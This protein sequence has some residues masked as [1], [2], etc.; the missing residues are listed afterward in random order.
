MLYPPMMTTAKL[1]ATTARRNAA[2]TVYS[3][4]G[5]L[6][7]K[8]PLRTVEKSAGQIGPQFALHR[9]YSALAVVLLY[10]LFLWHIQRH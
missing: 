8:A 10:C 6:S 2:V 5:R 4:G 3:M 9:N 7:I 1:P